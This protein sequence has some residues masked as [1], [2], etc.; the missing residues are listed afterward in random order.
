MG[1]YRFVTLWRLD[2]PIDRVFAEI[3]DIE[4]WPTWWRSVRAVERLAPGGND[5][6]GTSF[7]TTFQG[8][9]PYQLR[10]DLRTTR[11]DP[12]TSLAGDATG[13]LEGTGEWTLWQEGTWTHV[14]Y[15]W[16]I[17]TTAAWM[18]ALGRLPLVD[19]IFRLNHHA[20]MRDGLAGIRRRLGGVAG[21]YARED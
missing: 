3:D 9:L 15:V 13:E 8:R 10:F 20:V 19:A 14:C 4:S 1:S 12:P 2:A 21:T 6:I 18:N 16:A 17:R 7:R 5:G 11:R